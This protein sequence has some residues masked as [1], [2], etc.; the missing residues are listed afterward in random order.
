MRP[1]RFLVVMFASLAV[2]LLLVG[3]S[4]AQ[5]VSVVHSFNGTNGEFPQYVVLVQGRDGTLYGTADLGGAKG[6]GTIFR[7]H[8]RNRWSLSCCPA[9]RGY[10][11]KLLWCD[12]WRRSSRSNRLQT[13]SVGYLLHHLHT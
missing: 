7:Q 8:G 1:S 6:I 9:N 11:R 3:G 10:R 5:T 4:P 13:Y 2:L 12:E